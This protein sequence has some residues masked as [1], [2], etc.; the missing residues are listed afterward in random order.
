MNVTSAAALLATAAAADDVA[1]GLLALLAGAVADGRHAPGRLRVVAQ[2]RGA[3]ATAVRVVHW[4]HGRAAGLGAHAHVALAARLA[5]RDVLVVGVA[6]HADG[7]AALGAHHA[8]LAG[9]QAQRRHVALLGH[10]LDAR[11]GGAGEL[12]AAARLE[13]DVVHERADRHRGQRHRVADGDVLPDA[14]DDA[15]ADAQPVRGQDVALD[16][17]DVVQQRDVGRPVGVVLDRGDLRRHSVAGPLEVD[18]PVQALGAAATVAGGLTPV[19]VAAAGLG[20]ALDEGPLRRGL[21]DLGVV[22]VG[23]EPAAGRGGLGLADRHYRSASRPWKMGIDSP[24]RTCTIAF[25]QARV[26][27][28]V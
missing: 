25:F 1:I 16:A 24:S 9:G 15:H 5:H 28:L 26:R 20:Q 21:G 13:L 27:P 12:P 17:V 2:R 4:I 10:E 18:P 6:D 14:G 11:A 3:L 23:D 7:G 22:G 19:G 8:H